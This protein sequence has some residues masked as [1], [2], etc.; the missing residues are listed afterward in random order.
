MF[1]SWKHLQ[2]PTQMSSSHTSQTQLVPTSETP[3]IPTAQIQP[4]PALQ[5]PLV[6]T[7]LIPPMPT[8]QIYD[9]TFMVLWLYSFVMVAE[10]FC[11]LIIYE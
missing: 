3:P 5:M 1:V 4:I 2:F 9:H 8:T 6:P 7:S 11:N 10:Q